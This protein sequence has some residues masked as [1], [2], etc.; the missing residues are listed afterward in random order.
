M[1][2]P[3]QIVRSE[4]VAGR[5]LSNTAL[6]P[7]LHALR[8]EADVAPFEAG[9]FVRLELVVDGVKEARPYSL[10][11]APADP[12]VE[13]FF[14]TVPG[15]RLSNALAVLRAGDA[16]GISRPPTGFFT[17]G[18][19]PAARN[20]WMVATGTGLGP[21][22]SILR[23]GDV[24]EQFEHVVLVHGVPVRDELVYTGVI[25][26]VLSGY[27]GRFSFVPCVSRE[28]HPPGIR[29]RLTD[30]LRRGELERCAGRSLAAADSAV[31]LCG[32]QNMIDEMQGLL[33]GRDMR[34]H[35]RRKPGH[36]V[37]EQY[38]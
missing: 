23:A 16:V 33:A 25:G 18:Q 13:V 11:N 8:L 28:D 31:M 38:F 26:E 34:R 17:L 30:A 27:P 22:L 10:V 19:V 4:I 21:F 14:N 37:T 9:Q 35:L 36:F 24:W 2:A 5:V 20:L 32:N 7:R 29:G 1:A 3:T 15:G 12:T 6:A